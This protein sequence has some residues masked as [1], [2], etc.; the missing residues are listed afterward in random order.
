VHIT[1]TG[2]A[3]ASDGTARARASLDKACFGLLD[4]RACGEP[5][6]EVASVPDSGS[7]ELAV[8]AGEASIRI[9]GGP[10]HDELR[11]ARPG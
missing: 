3:D 10:H 1:P 9:A 2:P 4:A 8:I 5:S 6:L 7:G 11:C